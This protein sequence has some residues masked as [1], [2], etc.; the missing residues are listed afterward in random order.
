MR[1]E[2][3]QAIVRAIDVMQNKLGEPLSL[4]I[5]AE[6][7]VFSKFHFSRLF[8]RATGV[9]PG[10][11]LSALRLEKAKELLLSTEWNVVDIGTAV[12]YNSVGTFSTR[13]SRSVG[14]SPTNYRRFRGFAPCLGG[15]EP[16]V[17]SARRRRVRGT[18]SLPPGEKRRAVFVGLF[19]GPIPEGRPLA[20][21]LVAAPGPYELSVRATP[22]SHLLAFSLP[23]D[24][25]A[26]LH[27]LAQKDAR[28]MGGRRLGAL[29]PGP[30]LC[31]PDLPL[32]FRSRLDVPVLMATPRP[33]TLVRPGTNAGLPEPMPV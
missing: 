15:A 25:A 6:A 3:E 20:G 26:G 9:P 31:L 18:V 30:A 4:D 14:L 29:E 22:E 27:A 12:G 5:L 28:L 7:A 19:P 1:D 17:R 21:V 23:T 2:T 33:L 24:A 11:F 16:P 32:S 10:R 13:F 8:L